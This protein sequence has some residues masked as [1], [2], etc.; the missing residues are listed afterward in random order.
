MIC[1]CREVRTAGNTSDQTISFLGG[2]LL[3]RC[4]LCKSA[5]RNIRQVCNI[6]RGGGSLNTSP[7][8]C[9]QSFAEIDT[10]THG[11]S[12]GLSNMRENFLENGFSE[13][14]CCMRLSSK[15]HSHTWKPFSLASVTPSQGAFITIESTFQSPHTAAWLCL[16]GGG[17]QPTREETA[18]SWSLHWPEAN[19]VGSLQS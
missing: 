6:E 1:T 4:P 2:L 13:C 3:T 5:G 9:R 11:Q 17:A 8:I 19:E 15:L 14:G 16:D 7:T 12:T 10:C 18:S